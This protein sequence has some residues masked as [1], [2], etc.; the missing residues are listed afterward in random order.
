[1]SGSFLFLSAP[2]L[3]CRLG[4]RGVFLEAA[5]H[6]QFSEQMYRLENSYNLR[7]FDIAGFRMPMPVGIWLKSCIAQKWRARGAHAQS[8]IGGRLLMV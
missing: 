4:A 1:M 6:S 5:L 2:P 8:S 7:G 3:R